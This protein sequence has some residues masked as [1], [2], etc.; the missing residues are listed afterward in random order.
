MRNNN[1]ILSDEIFNE[2]FDEV[3]D[4]LLKKGAKLAEKNI[5]DSLK[6]PDTPVEF[7]KEHTNKIN[8]ILKRERN[9][10]RIQVMSR[11]SKY[12]ACFLLA[13]VLAGGVSILSVDAWRTQFL[14]FIFNPD[15]RG[16]AFFVNENG[17]TTYEGKH[18]RLDYVTYGFEVVKEE[19]GKH[20]S[21]ESVRFE[22][23]DKFVNISIDSI[24]T[25]VSIDTEDGTIE[26]INI[27]GIDG[28]YTSN[29]N[30]NS[31]VWHTEQYKICVYGNIEK[32]E[33][34]KISENLQLY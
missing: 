18:M 6:I 27:N 29:P 17:G 19:F 31:V 12:A 7:S 20:T 30:I 32:N 15:E 3:F 4:V 8:K 5:V 10:E 21:D 2:E 22:Y 11:I 26:P 16:T 24:D 33:L 1:D 25:I 14:N 34:V 13:V 23:A 28:Y 9:K